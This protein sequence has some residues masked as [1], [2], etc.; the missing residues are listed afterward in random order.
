MATDPAAPDLTIDA[1]GLLCPEPVLRV[2]AALHGQPDGV[3]LEV[4]TDDPMAEIDL[5]VF[6]DRA[7][8]GLLSARDDEGVRVTRIRKG[9]GGDSAAG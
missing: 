3:V 4:R 2:R 5:E 6:C 8:H 1:T 7:G 9:R